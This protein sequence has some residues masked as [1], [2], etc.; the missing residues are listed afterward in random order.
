M[1]GL[2]LRHLIQQAIYIVCIC[3]AAIVAFV[4]VD[5]AGQPDP[6]P[7]IL[8]LFLLVLALLALAHTLGYA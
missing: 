6:I 2:E 1:V 4:L 3:A 8:K 7:M 5:R